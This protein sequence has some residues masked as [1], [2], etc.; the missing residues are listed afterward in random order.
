MMT[1]ASSTA[2]KSQD[3][4]LAYMLFEIVTVFLFCQIIPVLHASYR[5][6]TR[7]FGIK[8]YVPEEEFIMLFF[9]VLNSSINFL[10]YCVSGSKF[11]NAMMDVFKCEKRIE[12]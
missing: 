8:S 7:D 4:S 5:Y 1:A 12:K 11:R 10:I 3:I 6:A 2:M 9:F